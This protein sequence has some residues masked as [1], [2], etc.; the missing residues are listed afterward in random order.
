MNIENEDKG[1]KRQCIYCKNYLQ[2]D[3]LICPSCGKNQFDITDEKSVETMLKIAIE[4]NPQMR[5]DDGVRPSKKEIEKAFE[6]SLLNQ[7]QRDILITVLSKS[8]ILSYGQRKVLSSLIIEL[9]HEINTE[10]RWERARLLRHYLK[11]LKM[12]ED[13]ID[14]LSQ[15]FELK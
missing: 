6:E 13:T 3:A 9:T 14:I 10:N 1:K 5:D 12:Q 15:V 4:K 11:T 7:K 8:D 2:I